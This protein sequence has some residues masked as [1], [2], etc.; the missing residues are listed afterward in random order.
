M[1]TLPK[2]KTTNPE[3]LLDNLKSLEES[4][5]PRDQET[6]RAARAFIAWAHR[7]NRRLVRE[8]ASLTTRIQTI[9]EVH[10][11]RLD[12]LTALKAEH[13]WCGVRLKG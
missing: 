1:T 8:R 7:E 13:A 3:R 11:N 6:V 9:L 5:V 4:L 12:E 2:T 10:Q